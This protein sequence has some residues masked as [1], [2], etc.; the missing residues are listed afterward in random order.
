[1]Q[2]IE[3]HPARHGEGGVGI[4]PIWLLARTIFTEA[5]RR[6]EIYVI[7]ALTLALLTGLATVRFFNMTSLSKF[8]Q[9]M[10]LNVMS[11]A[12]A[13]TVIV[14][15]A[16]QL[17]REFER[18]TIYTLLAKPVAR[19]QFIAGKYLGVVAAGGFCLAMFLG[20]FLGV[21]MTGGWHVPW[22]LFGQYLYLQI[23]LVAVLAALSLLLSM[24]VESDAAMT[25]GALLY[26]LGQLL[27]NALMELWSEVGVAGHVLLRVLNYSVPQADLFDL[28]EK[29][30]HDWPALGAGTLGWATVYALQF[31]IPYLVLCWLLFRRRPL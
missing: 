1:M 18:R 4:R 13:L 19:W 27:T 14:L 10:A 9:E 6:R 7:V 5:V 3:T 23:L 26:L 21:R 20:V 11:T 22:L 16:R 31:I 24:L 30:V 15:G 25:I 28:S 8:Y 17:P 29:I 12:T 2:A